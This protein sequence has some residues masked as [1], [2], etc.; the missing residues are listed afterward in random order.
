MSSNDSGEVEIA[1]LQRAQR[2]G[3][4]G[5][6]GEIEIAEMFLENTAAIQDLLLG[7]DDKNTVV[8]MGWS[9]VDRLHAPTLKCELAGKNSVG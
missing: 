5:D 3:V 1:L 6:I 8:R 7:K 2:V 4:F 9:C